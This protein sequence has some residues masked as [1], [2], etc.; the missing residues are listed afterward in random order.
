MRGLLPKDSYQPSS[1]SRGADGESWESRDFLNKSQAE[2]LLDWLE[3][4]GFSHRKVSLAENGTFT[5]HWRR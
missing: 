1:E 5:V 4:N 2:M 3:A